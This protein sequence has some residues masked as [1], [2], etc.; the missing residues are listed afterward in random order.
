MPI[1]T[2]SNLKV[3]HECVDLGVD[4]L[5]KNRPVP[6]SA[7]LNSLDSLGCV[8]HLQNL[9]P[10][11]DVLLS[12]KLQH[13]LHL[14]PVTQVAR[15]K[16]GAIAGKSLRSNVGQTFVRHADKDELFVNIKTSE[17]LVDGELVGGS[18]DD[19]EVK[20][21]LMAFFETLLASSDE[22]FGTHLHSIFLLGVGTRE[23]G[24][25]SAKGS[26]EE[27][28][29]VAAMIDVSVQSSLHQCPCVLLTDRPGQPHQPFCRDQHR[30]L[31]G[32]RR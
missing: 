14:L 21:E 26:T 3:L 17:E 19:D 28:G 10:R 13:L 7:V 30:S 1:G 27:N 5:D 12:G 32:E 18:S 8:L 6:D 31:Q 20:F 23:N 9:N 4:I 24:D 2:T 16:R 11:L 22:I 25:F 15:G 29:V